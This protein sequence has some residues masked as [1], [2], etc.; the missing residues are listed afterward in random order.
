V[1][2]SKSGVGPMSAL[3]ATSTQFHFDH[4]GMDQAMTSHHEAMTL[5]AGHVEH[6]EMIL[7]SGDA[8]FSGCRSPGGGNIESRTSGG[9]EGPAAGG[10]GDP[11]SAH[12][13]MV[14][15]APSRPPSSSGLEGRTGSGGTGGA[16]GGDPLT[17][18]LRLD[19]TGLPPSTMGGDRGLTL[20]GTGSPQSQ[21]F[22]RSPSLSFA[23]AALG[24]A[25]ALLA[26]PI[27]PP[28]ADRV[29]PSPSHLG[30]SVETPAHQPHEPATGQAAPPSSALSA[31]ADPLT[32]LLRLDTSSLQSSAMDHERG[33]TLSSKNLLFYISLTCSFLTWLPSGG[34][35]AAA[36]FSNVNTPQPP[37]S[38]PANAPISA[39][40]V[41]PASDQ[42]VVR[43]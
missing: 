36:F 33:L 38:Y 41:S 35:L 11:A 43:S 17:G 22:L 26:S 2:D 40:G 10:G 30:T 12:Q 8:L 18:L 34:S 3:V 15:R 1:L 23:A 39:L 27:A 24:P 42:Q 29:A 28:S 19:T 5:A 14:T 9:G 20:S 31:G 4:D 7:H 37:N 25:G 16:L 13:S 21:P 6:E 32:G